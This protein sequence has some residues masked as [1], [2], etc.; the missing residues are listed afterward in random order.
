M[1][2]AR[3]PQRP[4]S[5]RIAFEDGQ[6]PALHA[7]VLLSG[8]PPSCIPYTDHSNLDTL[9]PCSGSRL[10]SAQAAMHEL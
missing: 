6:A 9:T 1:P 7:S 4:C 8:T 2:A 5:S 10:R 3:L